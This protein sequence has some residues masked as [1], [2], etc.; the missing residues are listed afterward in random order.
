[1]MIMLRV[2][3]H[4]DYD[5]WGIEIL[6]KFRDSEPLQVL[7]DTRQSGGVGYV[8]NIQER[9]ISTMLYLISLQELCQSPFRVVDEINQG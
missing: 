2:A 9:A 4:A 8:S 6:V 1:M 7:T 5:K 3:T